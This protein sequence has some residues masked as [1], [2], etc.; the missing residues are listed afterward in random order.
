MFRAI[1]TFEDISSREVLTRGPDAVYSII[2]NSMSVS[3]NVYF[4]EEGTLSV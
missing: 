1:D 3:R 4:G 2:K